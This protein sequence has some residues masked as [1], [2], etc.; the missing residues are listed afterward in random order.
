MS[1]LEKMSNLRGGVIYG[2]ARVAPTTVHSWGLALGETRGTGHRRYDVADALALV[3]MRQLTMEMSI[4]A[5]PAALIVNTL[6]PGL[7]DEIKAVLSENAAAGKW[8]WEGGPFAVVRRK[9]TAHHGADSSLWIE[10][11]EEKDIGHA[12]VSDWSGMSPLVIPFRRLINKTL[13]ALELVLNGDIPS[14]DE[15]QAA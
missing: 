7:L 1:K 6:R 10:M 9:P 2:A 13:L 8:R 12:I 11:V 3:I 4:A 14:N 5:G 15:Q